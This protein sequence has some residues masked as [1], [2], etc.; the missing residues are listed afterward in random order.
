MD[1]GVDTG[2]IIGQKVISID[3]FE[4]ATSLYN[5]VSNAHADLIKEIWFNLLDG[6]LKLRAQDETL[7]SYWN[8]RSVE[9][10]EIKS[11]MSVDEVDRLVRAT[12]KPYPG[13]FVAMNDST[14]LIVW[15]G[16]FELHE[17]SYPIKCN[18][19]MFYA[20]DFTF[21]SI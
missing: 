10:G 11:S 5:S 14:K 15:S 6:S 8:G 2:P 12:T 9:D 16:S 13:A 17:N 1:S 20:L 3:P 4:N 7:A 21:S 19:G 18:N